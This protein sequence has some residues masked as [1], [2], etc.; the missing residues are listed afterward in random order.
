MRGRLALG[1]CFAIVTIAATSTIHSGAAQAAGQ[2]IAGRAGQTP[3]TPC[4]GRETSSEC[5][6]YRLNRIDT[7]LSEMQMEIDQLKSRP[8]GGVQQAGPQLSE[9]TPP[10]KTDA[11]ITYLQDRIDEITKKVNELVERVNKL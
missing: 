2:G 10:P 4:V 3:A 5:V 1:V 8:V 9:I 7:R 11:S 6:I